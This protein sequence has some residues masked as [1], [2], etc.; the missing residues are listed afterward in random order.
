MSGRVLYSASFGALRNT[1]RKEQA[2]PVPKALDVTKVLQ[3][4]SQGSDAAL[5]ELFPLIQ[6]ELHRLARRYMFGERP[7]HTLQT[8]ALVN[9]AY[10]R[11]VNYRKVNWQN[12]LHFFAI[13]AQLMRRILV[14]YARARGFQKRG[15]GVPKVTLDEALIGPQ[16]TG[17]DL[18]ALDDTLRALAGVDPRKIKVVELRLFGGLSAQETAEVLKVSPDTVLRDWRLAKAWLA[19]EMRKAA[20]NGNDA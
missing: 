9:E 18:V 2:M 6:Q 5:E 14:D 16:E 8:T 15:G 10:L 20:A 13:S 4:W 12:R 17:H 3:A 1:A 11:L 7:D 19:R